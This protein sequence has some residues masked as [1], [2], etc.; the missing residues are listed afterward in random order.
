MTTTPRILPMVERPRTRGDCVDGPRPCPWV[1][2]RYHLYLDVREGRRQILISNWPNIPPDELERMPATCALDVADEGEHNQVH[3]AS[4]IGLG[5]EQAY[6]AVQSKAFEK[7]KTAMNGHG[8]ERLR[9][10]AE[11]SQAVQPSSAFETADDL[12]VFWTLDEAAK[13]KPP[14]R[15]R[16]RSKR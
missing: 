1:S 11:S 3:T 4:L 7:L 9:D 13:L 16:K 10:L 5:S 14:I 12:F 2:C 6:Q 15:R 8:L